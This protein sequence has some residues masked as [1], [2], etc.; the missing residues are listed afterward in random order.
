VV[1]HVDT[2]CMHGSPTS[3]HDNR[4]LFKVV[5]FREVGLLGEPYISWANS[6]LA[7]LTDTGRCWDAGSTNVRDQL[8]GS[9]D[10]EFR[11]T[12][13]ICA[14]IDRNEFPCE[15]M[16]TTHPQRWVGSFG[17]WCWELVAQNVKNLAKVLRGA[18]SDG[19]SASF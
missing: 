8:E 4:L 16:V 17:P 11:S 5:T 12:F 1:A 14:A 7:Y 13:H 18:L 10:L 6:G 2:V 19:I 9:D 15:V 3:N